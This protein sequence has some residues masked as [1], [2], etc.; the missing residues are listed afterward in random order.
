MKYGCQ[1]TISSVSSG[2]FLWKINKVIDKVVFLYIF[3]SIKLNTSV[4]SVSVPGS[5]RLR[6]TINLA[7][8][9]LRK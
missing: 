5:C 7:A 6:G 9:L 2:P 1:G 3:T 4:C 8:R